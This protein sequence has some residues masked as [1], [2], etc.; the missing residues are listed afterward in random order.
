MSD[1][2]DGP[3]QIG[4]PSAD[5][6]DLF[7]F[8]S[9]ENP[10]RTVLAANVFPT[11]GRDAMFSNAI[12]H[13]IVVRRAKITGLGDA[14]KFE[15][16]DPEV[17]FSVRFDTLERGGAGQ[18]PVQRGTCTFPDGQ[19]LRIVVN[20]EKGASTPDGTFRVFAGL[21]SDPFILAWLLQNMKPFQNLLLHDNVL[22]I[23]IEFDTRRVL[24]PEKGSLFG[25]IAETVPLTHLGEFVGSQPPRID[26]VGR[27]EQTNIRLN[28][29][30]VAGADD[31][32]DLWNQQTPFAIDEKVRPLFLQRLKDSLANWDLRDGKQDWTPEA[33][34]ANANMFLEDYLLFD[35]AKPITDNSHLEIEKS[36]LNGKAYETGGGRTVDADV[37]DV[38]ITWMVNRDRE[39]LRGGTTKATKPGMKSF[40]YFATPNLDLQ[41]VSDS[42]NLDTP[43]NKVWELVGQF[44]G[45]WHPLIAQIKLIGSGIGQLRVIETIDGKQ[46][47]ERLDAIDNSTHSYRYT[48]IAG[49]P[50]S[51][52]TGTFQVKP[53]GAGSTVEWRA[54]YLGNG[55]GDLIVKT[56]VA[57]LFKTGLESLK[58]RFG[59]AQ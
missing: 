25:A 15:T 8:T 12:T 48:N 5:L 36:T 45:D 24:E 46:I 50:A 31:V 29:Q 22:C 56:I 39:P 28:N 32:R 27:P 53:N 52:Y 59:A 3:R 20:D 23:V 38:L 42:I 7:A 43:P 26:W 19:T 34:A 6:T 11:C 33:L 40:P 57:T 2:I 16:A 1:H 35:V 58:P 49:I 37:I 14:T 55:Q 13:S 51:D 17:R 18:K 41:Q 47:I 54:Q 30:G 4:D 10:S 9:P 44:G 21:R